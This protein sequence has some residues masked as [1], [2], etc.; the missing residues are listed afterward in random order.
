MRDTPSEKDH[1]D[2]AD[3]SECV[4]W[5]HELGV[6]AGELKA[7]V[8]YVGPRAEDVRRYIQERT[9]RPLGRKPLGQ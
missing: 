5:T 4:R 9:L 2:V 1:I 7:A 6:T 3:E 8:H